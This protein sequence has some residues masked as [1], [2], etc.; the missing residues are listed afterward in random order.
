MAAPGNPLP[1]LPL[2]APDAVPMNRFTTRSVRGVESLA[3]ET[4]FAFQ[5]KKQMNTQVQRLCIFASTSD[6]AHI[7]KGLGLVYCR[8]DNLAVINVH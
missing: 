1:R 4:T 2:F 3:V 8:Q 5:V 7:V 6:F